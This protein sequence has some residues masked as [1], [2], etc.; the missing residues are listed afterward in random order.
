MTFSTPRGYITACGIINSKLGIDERLLTWFKTIGWVNLG[1]LP[2][3][4]HKYWT[5]FSNLTSI[6]LLSEINSVISAGVFFLL[7]IKKSSII[8]PKEKLNGDSQ[9]FVWN[10]IWT[11]PK[12]VGYQLIA[13][14]ERIII[15]ALNLPRLL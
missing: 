1:K 2:V 3:K 4:Y 13:K 15:R 11:L 10:L 9:Y 14:T 12:N 8:I 7:K 5:T 6:W